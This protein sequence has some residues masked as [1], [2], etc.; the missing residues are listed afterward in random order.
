MFFLLKC[1]Y[2][3]CK[4]LQKVRY[5]SCRIQR[6]SVICRSLRSEFC[7]GTCDDNYCCSDPKKIFTWEA[8]SD[9]FFDT[10]SIAVSASIIGLVAFIILFLI[11]WVCPRC[12]LYKR[13]R[14]PRRKSM[15]V[16]QT[17]VVTTQYLPQPSAVI[18]GSQYLPYQARPNIPPYGGQ[19]IPAGSPPSYQEAVGPGCP[20]PIQVVFDGGQATY[21]LQSS[22]P[23]DY[24]SPQPAY[25]PAYTSCTSS[26]KTSN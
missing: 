7:C 2:I 13:F 24:T 3:L 9:C 22:L 11:C 19:P 21:P 15:F 16:R 6:E 10:V 1:L 4:L 17:T 14:S 25:N 5:K 8:Q 26:V 12:Y 23:T 18:Q 20:V